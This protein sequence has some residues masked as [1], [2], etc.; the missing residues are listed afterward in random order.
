MSG[1]YHTLHKPLLINSLKQKSTGIEIICIGKIKLIWENFQAAQGK[2]TTNY[3]HFH[4]IPSTKLDVGEFLPLAFTFLIALIVGISPSSP[5]KCLI[6]RVS[7]SLDP[8]FQ[9][10]CTPR[11]LEPLTSHFQ[12]TG[13]GIDGKFSLLHSVEHLLHGLRQ[14]L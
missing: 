4:W 9:L 8:V 3:D 13:I 5:V 10:V 14:N 7:H 12:F 2:G 1:K 11:L 6:Y